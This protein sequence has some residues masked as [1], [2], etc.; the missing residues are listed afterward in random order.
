MG[1]NAQRARRGLER[2]F[3]PPWPKRG[4]GDHLY[5]RRLVVC[6]DGSECAVTTILDP[7]HKEIPSPLLRK[8]AD[9]M[10]V[11]RDRVEEV[12]YEWT[13]ERYLEHCATLTRDQLLPPALLRGAPGSRPP[14]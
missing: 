8:M 9:Q 7:G 10:G 14:S 11:P 4:K 6:C 2:I 5:F 3:G 13:A 12:L 1:V